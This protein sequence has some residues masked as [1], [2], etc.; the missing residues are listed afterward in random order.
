MTSQRW[1]GGNLKWSFHTPLLYRS[2]AEMEIE[3][4]LALEFDKITEAGT[5]LEPISGPG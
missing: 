3:Q 1:A 4:N 5:K 2:I